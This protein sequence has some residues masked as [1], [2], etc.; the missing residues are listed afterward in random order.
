MATYAAV[1]TSRTALNS[2]ALSCGGCVFVQPTV[3]HA[4][5]MED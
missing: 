1:S 2:E 4:R 3:L 5:V